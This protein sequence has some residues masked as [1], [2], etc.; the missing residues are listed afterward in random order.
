MTDIKH[1]S[2][3]TKFVEIYENDIVLKDEKLNHALT[4]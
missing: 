2:E 1:V 3:D 4:M